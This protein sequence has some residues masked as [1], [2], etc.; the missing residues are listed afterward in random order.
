MRAEF[1]LL[2][3]HRLRR[4]FM[5]FDRIAPDSLPKFHAIFAGA[6]DVAIAQLADAGIKFLSPLARNEL[7]RRQ[8]E[9]AL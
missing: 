1:T 2:E 7:R 5:H 8:P 6:G 3:I 9:L 4:E